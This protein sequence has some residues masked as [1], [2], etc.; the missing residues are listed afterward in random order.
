M[1]VIRILSLIGL[2]AYLVL[3]G[4]FYLFESQSP[5]LHAFIGIIGLAAGVLMF[6]SLTHWFDHHKEK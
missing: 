1:K 3:E 6:I 5:V 2:A 4:I